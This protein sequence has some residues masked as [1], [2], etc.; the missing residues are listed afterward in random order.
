MAYVATIT[1]PADHWLFVPIDAWSGFSIYLWTPET[2]ADFSIPIIVN[3]VS[4]SAP[5]LQ[6]STPAGPETG[7]LLAPHGSFSFSGH[8]AN[9]VEYGYATADYVAHADIIF[10]PPGVADAIGK[11]ARDAGTFTVLVPTTTTTTE[12]SA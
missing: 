9:T 8:A 6:H 2:E 4:P 1:S 3:G 10:T 11:I 5:E 12:P 7:L